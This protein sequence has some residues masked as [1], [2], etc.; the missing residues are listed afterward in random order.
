MKKIKNTT[1]KNRS[2]LTSKRIE[3][4]LREG[5]KLRQQVSRDLEPLFQIKPETLSLILRS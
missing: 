2:N 1:R 4:L 3:E 5:R